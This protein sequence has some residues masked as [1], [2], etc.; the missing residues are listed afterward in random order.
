MSIPYELTYVRFMIWIMNYELLII[1][2]ARH[3]RHPF[4]LCDTCCRFV[5]V[6]NCQLLSNASHQ[7]PNTKHASTQARHST[8][9]EINPQNL[10][11]MPPYIPY[12]IIDM[13]QQLYIMYD[14]NHIIPSLH[15]LSIS[16]N[17]INIINFLLSSFHPPINWILLLY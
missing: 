6:T 4:I 10:H 14:I 12:D 8:S 1:N 11:F 2:N 15:M 13:D 17:T 7:A 9:T 16:I 5:F 3:A